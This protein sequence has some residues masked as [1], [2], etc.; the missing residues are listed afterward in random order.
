VTL[1][2]TGVAEDEQPIRRPRQR[3]PVHQRALDQ[4]LVASAR[5]GPTRIEQAQNV[6]ARDSSLQ[7]SLQL[8]AFSLDVEGSC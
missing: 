1:D 3:D 4:D 2:R 5:L 7:F 6:P 8:W